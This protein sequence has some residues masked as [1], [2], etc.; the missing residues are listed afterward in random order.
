M[1]TGPL[2]PEYCPPAHDNIGYV[3]AGGS[4]GAFP[5]PAEIMTSEQARDLSK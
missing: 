1:K 2:P 4:Y 5:A 3:E